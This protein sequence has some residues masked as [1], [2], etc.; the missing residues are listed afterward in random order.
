M[1]LCM[2][3]PEMVHIHFVSKFLEPTT[4]SNGDLELLVVIFAAK[5]KTNPTTKATSLILLFHLTI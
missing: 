2:F 5:A 1:K 4:L 3:L